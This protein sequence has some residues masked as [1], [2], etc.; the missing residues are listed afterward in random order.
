MLR[1]ISG[2]VRPKTLTLAID[3][4]ALPTEF[5]IWKAGV[6]PTTNGYDVLFD[7]TSAKLVMEAYEKHAVDIMIDLEHLSLED[8]GPGHDPDARGWCN[9]ALRSGE[10]WAV[11]VRWTD[12]GVA[13]LT[14]KTQRYISPAFTLD[15]ENRPT[16]LFNIGLVAMPATDDGM[17]LVAARARFSKLSEG[18]SMNDA[19]RAI[20]EALEER[21]PV[22]PGSSCGGPWVCDVFVETVVYEFDGKLF[23]APY[24]FDGSCAVVGE[25]VEVKKIYAPVG[26]PSSVPSSIPPPTGTEPQMPLTINR[27]L[28]ALKQARTLSHAGMSAKSVLAMLADASGDTS[29][30]AAGVDIAGLADFLAITINPAQDP[31]GFVKALMAKLDEISAA[32]K[33]ESPAPA[34]DPSADPAAP[35][36]DMAAT[37]ALLQICGAKNITEAIVTVADWRKLAIDNANALQKIADERKALE[38]TKKRAIGARLV[39][40]GA[41]LPSTAWADDAKTKLAPHLASMTVE[42]LEERATAFEAKNGAGRGPLKPNT[43]EVELSERELAMC[44][45]LKVDP[46]LYAANKQKR[47]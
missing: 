32:L 17:A 35:A 18:A 42:Q 24:A 27:A 23:E 29:G 30:E 31:A 40:C 34:A 22:D 25:G 10:L 9:L 19:M 5:R 33:G 45:E 43:N 41:E 2:R 15:D 20:S 47:A 6:N 7:E 36:G 16:R 39:V 44:A 46:K 3:G 21:C 14:S 11:N 38:T 37:R 26:A 1:R 4:S 28:A 13:R 12:D 8:P